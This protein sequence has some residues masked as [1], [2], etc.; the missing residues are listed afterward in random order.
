M[1]GLA[2]AGARDVAFA[3]QAVIVT[4]ALRRKRRSARVPAPAV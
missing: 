3:E 2:G 4:V 1:R